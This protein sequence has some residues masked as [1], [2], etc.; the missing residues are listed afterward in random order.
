MKLHR[1]ALASLALTC[2]LARA[3]SSDCDTFWDTGWTNYTLGPSHISGPEDV[4]V[5]DDFDYTGSLGRMFV[6]GHGPFN[7]SYPVDGVWLRFYAWSASGPGA[8]QHERFLAAGDANLGVLTI[9]ATIDITLAPPFVASGKHFVS[10]QIDF[11][12][13]G[14]YWWPW[15]GSA[16]TPQ[17]THAW[18]RDNLAGGGW[19]QYSDVLGPVNKDMSFAL[20]AAP[21]PSSCAEWSATPTPIPSQDY[22]ILRDLHVLAGDDVWAV[23]HF[24][25][26]TPGYTEQITLAMHFDGAQWSVTPTPSPAPGPNLSNDYLW[27]VDGVA[28]NDVWAGGEQNMQ[29]PG[30]WVGSQ[31]LGIHWDGSTW[32]EVPMPIPPT[33][34][35]AGYT[36]SSVLEIEAIAS[37][38]VWF[39]GRW[40]GPYPGT[41]STRPAMAIHWDGSGFTQFLAPVIAG[42]QA[43]TAADSSSSSNVWAVGTQSSSTTQYPYV[44][45]WDGAN[46]SHVLMPPAGTTSQVFDIDVVSANEVWVMALR[47]VGTTTQPFLMKW[48]GTSWSQMSVPVLA[49]TLV[50]ASD[51][52]WLAGAQIHHWNGSDWSVVDDLGCIPSPSFANIAGSGA[53]LWAA[54]RQLGAGLIPLVARRT[55]QSCSVVSYCTSSTTTSGCSPSMSAIGTPSASASNGFTLRATSVEGQRQGLIFYGVS[56][57]QAS[58]WGAGSTSYLCVKPP[59]Q[60]MSA[61]ASGGTLFQCDGVLAQDWSAFMATHPGVLGQPRT[62]GQSLDAQAWFRDAAAPK[63]TNLSDALHF[64]LEP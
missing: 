58:P 42:Q 7:G 40:N 28:A 34:V 9:P 39:L 4:E 19:T 41:S 63:T 5:A 13:S 47:N 56:G 61:L 25:Q 14:G 18:R 46:W 33:S 51:D 53:N 2:A 36:G 29:V 48:N 24:Q 20:H 26:L 17:L 50:N 3:S 21:N 31:P 64:T 60:R 52:I 32:S 15:T 35:G 55:G 57:Q 22:T 38:D 8:L 44:V 12:S 45:R 30:G 37:N 1:I 54:G 43:I 49:S 27:A 23:G 10:V 11:A 16:A 62:T 6:N 59:V